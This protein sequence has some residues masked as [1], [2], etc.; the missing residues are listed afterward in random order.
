FAQADSSTTRRYGGTGLG[1]SI[2]K[3]LC[4]MMGGTI[5]LT[6]EPGQGSTFRFTARFGRVAEAGTSPFEG[7]AV[8]LV[9]SKTRR[10]RDPKNELSTWGVRVS[11]AENADGA[12][13]EIAAAT[14]RGDPFNLAV[15][16]IALPGVSG[17]E[18]ARRIKA[19]PAMADLRL[20][21]MTSDDHEM[22]EIGDMRERVVGCLNRPVRQSALRACLAATE[23]AMDPVPQ[24]ASLPTPVEGA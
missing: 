19:D 4:E 24:P 17:I 15:I 21:L 8:L 14:S 10:R 16:D 12:L 5:E 1:L 23:G 22:S 11:E 2:A 13:A 7:M 18:L 20:V 6:S 3:Q 9:E